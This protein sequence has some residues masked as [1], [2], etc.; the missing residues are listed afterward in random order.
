MRAG[1]VTL[2]LVYQLADGQQT[3]TKRL[4]ATMTVAKLHVLCER[5]FSVPSDCQVPLRTALRWQ[6]GSCLAGLTHPV[7]DHHPIA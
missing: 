1:T 4:P 5:L 2:Q 3:V 7:S 6:T